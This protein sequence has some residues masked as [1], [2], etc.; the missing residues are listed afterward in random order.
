MH[1]TRVRGPLPVLLTLFIAVCGW[2]QSKDQSATFQITATHN[3]VSSTSGMQ[4]PLRVAWS[5]N[6]GA[7]VSYPLIAGGR[8]FVIAGDYTANSVN[9]Y[10]LDVRNGTVLWGPVAIARGYYWWA[11]A[12]YDNGKIFVVPNTVSGLVSGAMFAYDAASGKQ[13]WSVA[14][15]GQYFFT[16]PPTA[17]NG[18]VYTGG[19]GS[20]GTVYAVRETDGK[21]LWT[22]SVENGDGSSPA[23][24]SNGVYVSYACP[25]SYRFNPATGALV[26]HYSGPCEGGGGLTPV[27]YQGGLYVRDSFFVPHNGTILN[28][29]T[30]AVLGYFD[31]V[32]PPV[33]SDGTAFYTQTNSLTAMDVETGEV[34]WTAAPA[35]GDSYTISPVIVNG[36][37]YVGTALGNVLGYKTS[38]GKKVVSTYVGYP[39]IGSEYNVSNPPVGM[40]AAQGVLVVPAGTHVVALKH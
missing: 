34:Y 13:L 8:V 27:L 9:M 2:T 36:V 6:L 4:P 25:Q 10:A 20:G 33:F 37:V 1:A 16:S 18:V 11:A 29:N 31:S 5:V 38:S 26:W 23:V 30:G 17:L 15:P 24:S 14:L 12:A 19:A 28:A 40:G 3:A 21:V 22:G 32:Y 7:T 39:V 35:T